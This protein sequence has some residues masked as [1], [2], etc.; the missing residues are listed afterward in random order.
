MKSLYLI[1]ALQF[2]V[3]PTFGQTPLYKFKH[4]TIAYTNANTFQK[5]SP[6]DFANGVGSFDLTLPFNFIIEGITY[7]NIS[8]LEQGAVIFLTPTD[9]VRHVAFALGADLVA[10]DSTSGVYT[11]TTGFVG[12]RVFT[13]EFRWFGIK[14]GLATDFTNFSI[15]LYE[16]SNDFEVR[17]GLHSNF[18][19]QLFLLEK[20]AMA[21]L[22][23]QDTITSAS[24]TSYFL[25]DSAHTPTFNIGLP[26]DTVQFSVCGHPKTN[27]SYRFI[28]A[29]NALSTI[30]K[31]KVVA[32]IYPNPVNT[33]PFFIELDNT[34]DY[35]VTI[36]NLQGKTVAKHSFLNT[37]RM[38]ITT[39]EINSGIYLLNISSVNNVTITKKIIIN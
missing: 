10:K 13:I 3:L 7:N 9:K 33:G 6:Q 35:I 22:F 21:G 37:N 24:D 25:T 16:G 31:S 36:S 15:L 32:K 12:N 4:G 5:E 18:D 20:G 11:E 34:D 38:E 23:V 17:Y 2:I 26:P 28:N 30:T 19:T 27:T 14:N 29:K 39:D 1:F 8:I